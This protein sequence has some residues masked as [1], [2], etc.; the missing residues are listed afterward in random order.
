MFH[1]HFPRLKDLTHRWSASASQYSEK[2]CVKETY[3]SVKGWFFTIS[4]G[5]ILE[6]IFKKTHRHKQ[7]TNER[8]FMCYALPFHALRLKKC[9]PVWAVPQRWHFI[10]NAVSWRKIK[11]STFYRISFFQPR[12]INFFISS[13]RNNGAPTFV[14]YA[15]HASA[16]RSLKTCRAQKIW[17]MNIDLLIWIIHE[18][19][20]F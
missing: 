1:L 6:H 7:R 3:D 17:G 4:L 2:M 13:F 5:C 12:R 10:I 16:Q 9:S 20:F 14:R 15:S 18:W 19:W 8:A 11:R